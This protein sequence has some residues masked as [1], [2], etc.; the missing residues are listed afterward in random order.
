M[1]IVNVY[2]KIDFVNRY[3][4]ICEKH[5]DF[6]NRIE[7]NKIILY[8]KTLNK[9]NVNYKY[10]KKD[11][12]F[13]VQSTINECDFKLHL[14]LRGGLV[15]VLIYIERGKEY[16]KP[17]G[18]FDFIPEELGM[19]F[20]RKIYNLPKYTTEN[21]LEEIL[22]EIFSIYEDFKTEF[23]KELELENE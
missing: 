12:F 17:N 1:N 20:N 5:N 16:F 7:G 4:L 13:Q 3:K 21:E 2:K 15:E 23:L 19:E 9:L 11:R 18:R 8:E 10:N 6:T 22:K 14:D